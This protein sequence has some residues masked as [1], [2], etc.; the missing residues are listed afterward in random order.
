MH[1]L[2]PGSSTWKR[3]WRLLLLLGTSQRS[4]SATQN[5][6][7]CPVVLLSCRDATANQSITLGVLAGGSLA[8]TWDVGSA[9][10][11]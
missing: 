9:R 6:S 8:G 5:V 2:Q 10:P 7:S 3:T 11:L 4:T 1:S